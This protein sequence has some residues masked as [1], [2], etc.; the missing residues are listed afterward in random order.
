MFLII[1]I[2]YW[3][4]VVKTIGLSSNLEIPIEIII[5]TVPLRPQSVVQ[6]C[7]PVTP[8]TPPISATLS[9]PSLDSYDQRE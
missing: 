3:Q 7:L 8:S 9:V 1:F 4:L 6:G 5:G 2:I